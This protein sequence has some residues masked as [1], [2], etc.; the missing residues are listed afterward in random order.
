MPTGRELKL[1]ADKGLKKRL[2]RPGQSGALRNHSA[3]ALVIAVIL[4][5]ANV[6]KVSEI[7]LGKTF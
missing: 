7:A 1:G 6:E 2:L 3:I 4:I 5:V